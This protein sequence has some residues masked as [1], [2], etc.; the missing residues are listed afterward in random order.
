MCLTDTTLKTDYQKALSH[1][2]ALTIDSAVNNPSIV[3]PSDDRFFTWDNEKRSPAQGKPYLFSWSYYNGVVME[4]LL[5]LWEV[6]D[7][8][9][10]ASYVST[11]LHSMM[12]GSALNAYAG[13]VP[14]HGLDCYK[15]AQ[16]LHFFP[17]DPACRA[18][19]NK[20]WDDLVIT[21]QRYTENELGG[22]YWHSWAGQRAPRYKVWLDGL[23]MAQP[24][25]ANHAYLASDSARLQEVARRFQWVDREL[26]NEK[27][28]LLYHAGNCSGDVCPFHWTRAIGWYMMALVDVIPF[29]AEEDQAELI[30]ILRRQIAALLKCAHPETGL[31]ANLADRPVTDTNRLETSASSMIIYAILKALRMGW[32]GEKDGACLQ[33]SLI[34]YHSLVQNHLTPQ[35]L[36]DT[37][38]VAG[39]NGENGYEIP[40]RYITNE[41]KGVGPFLM[42]T[43]EIGHYLTDARKERAKA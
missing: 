37:Y 19:A 27:N 25:I 31:W 28:G 22:N 35:G 30:D 3:V 15:T 40:E 36:A 6:E 2:N 23:Y 9:S 5:K 43:A 24:F 4:G 38:L 12:D 26:K 39:A 7:D 17:D 29:L 20:L 21:N 11:Y 33:S 18:L 42:A 1:A 13:Y 41:G 10:Y 8:I 32:I 14:Y 34:A 16:L